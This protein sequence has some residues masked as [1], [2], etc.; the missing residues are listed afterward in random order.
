MFHQDK[1]DAEQIQV[2]L[3]TNGS[4]L[5]KFSAIRALPQIVKTCLHLQRRTVVA[6]ELQADPH[7]TWKGEQ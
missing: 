5:C 4:K 2:E 7:F 1:T 3:L 6:V